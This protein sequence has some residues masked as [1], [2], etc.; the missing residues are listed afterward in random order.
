MKRV[1]FLSLVLFLINCCSARNKYT[2][3][4]KNAQEVPIN[5]IHNNKDTLIVLNDSLA[6][7]YGSYN[8]EVSLWYNLY[9]LKKGDSI[10]LIEDS[11][12]F[13]GVG[14]ELFYSLSPNSKYIV[15]DGIIKGYVYEN[16]KDSTLH[17]NYSCAL[18]DIDKV[19][20]IHQ[21]QQYCSGYWNIKNQWISDN[22][23]IFDGR[24][25]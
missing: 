16:K 23:I 25:R 21:W 18:I 6:L 12:D 15:V 13:F 19:S 24:R 17:E 10:K 4:K 20:E 9:I 14:S 22:Q 3:I 8:K 11:Y 5:Y 7:Y 2:L 1:F